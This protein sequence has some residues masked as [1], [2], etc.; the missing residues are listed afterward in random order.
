V[1]E[2]P[3]RIKVGASWWQIH[4]DADERLGTDHFGHTHPVR[5]EIAIQT[6]LGEQL[7]R[8]TLTHE[9]IHAMLFD[10]LPPDQ[11]PGELQVWTIGQ[12]LYQF[13]Q[14]NPTAVAW[15]CQQQSS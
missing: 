15:L 2:Q 1:T 13:L 10:A 5:L 7:E 3:K 9:I 11:R 4:W 8:Q 14:E 6:K 12:L